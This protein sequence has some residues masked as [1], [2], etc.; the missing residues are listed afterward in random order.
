MADKR[1]GSSALTQ[2]QQERQRRDL[3]RQA[4]EQAP[5]EQR[6]RGREAE[7]PSDITRRGWKDV[8]LRVKDQLK[9]DNVTLMAAG[10]AFYAMLA[11]FP[12]LIAALTIYGLVADPQDV[13]QQ[14]GE[15]TQPLPD[16]AAG[17]IEGALEGAT[18]AA[19]GGL[20]IGL[21]ASVGAALWTASGGM[22]GLIKGINTAYDERETRGFLKLRGLALLLTLGAI[23]VGLVAI[24]LIAVVPALL[25]NIGLGDEAAA[26]LQWGRWPLLALLVI[27]GLAIIYRFAPDRDAPQL[28]WVSW[29]AV[30]ATVLWLIASGLFSL[31]VTN[32]GNY[33]A[34]YGALAGVIILLL[35]LFL[36]S[37]VILLG[38][39]INAEM[40]RQTRKD[41][42]K[43][44]VDPMGRREA[45]AADTVG[46]STD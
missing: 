10:V 2:Q 25:G 43:G 37:F 34:T 46:E 29:G 38:A 35:W 5:S 44:A 27:T 13:T 16:D 31:Y 18:G 33:E 12:A 30:I 1:V 22:N 11:I 15:L 6:D 8:A 26:A 24:G 28:R 45:Y 9:E 42:T 39:E 14:V 4:E 36:T 19:A 21:I 32:F 7:K 23:V 17:L 41:T 40:E 20:T 3:A